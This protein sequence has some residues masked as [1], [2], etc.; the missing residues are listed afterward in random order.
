M[1]RPSSNASTTDNRRRTSSTLTGS[2]K[3]VQGDARNV[4]RQ[5]YAG[6]LWTKQFYYYVAQRWLEGDP[7]QPAPPSERLN[8][9]NSDWR[10]LFCRDIL[11][12]PDK[13]E[14]P[15][16]ASW[17]TA[18]HMIPMG[19]IDPGYA[20]T[21]LLILLREWYLHPNGQM[22]AYE[23]KFSDVNPPVHA[24]SADHVYQTDA[25]TYRCQG[26]RLSG[27]VFSEAAHELYLVGQPQRR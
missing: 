16:F 2:R 18:F 25:E 22:P 3:Q 20:K 13:W 5:A 10:H 9:P 19:E 17:D 8:S 23:F 27:A 11:S 14:Y 7:A 15:W 1:S 12:V 26:H 24:W 21:Q 6:L 4:A